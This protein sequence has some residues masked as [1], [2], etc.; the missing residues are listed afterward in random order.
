MSEQE[1]NIK[2]KVESPEKPKLKESSKEIKEDTQEFE[3]ALDTK[4]FDQAKADIETAADVEE[5]QTLANGKLDK[6]GRIITINTEDR[7]KIK[8]AYSDI[9]SFSEIQ[10]DM[11]EDQIQDEMI[12]MSDIKDAEGEINLSEIKDF[13]EGD[14][15]IHMNG[16]GVPLQEPSTLSRIGNKIKGIFSAE[17]KMEKLAENDAALDTATE[18]AANVQAQ[19]EAAGEAYAKKAFDRQENGPGA[20][21]KAA[22]SVA[23]PLN[24][25]FDKATD[26]AMKGSEPEIAVVAPNEKFEK[27]EEQWENL[28]SKKE[29]IEN[30]K[31]GLFAPSPKFEKKTSNE[32]TGSTKDLFLK[33]AEELSLYLTKKGRYKEA[34]KVEDYTEEV[35]QLE[36]SIMSVNDSPTSHPGDYGERAKEDKVA[37]NFGN[38]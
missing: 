29:E 34:K 11:K 27:A 25:G 19:K 16:P 22:M 17:Q 33:N 4:G 6:R 26:R 7:K 36:N 31:T 8:E 23:E 28:A 32:Y 35:Q 30:I 9:K 1:K 14:D 12:S 38:T 10:D 37:K 21:E 13:Q 2:P 24:K 20:V 3:V 5:V 15:I 18:K